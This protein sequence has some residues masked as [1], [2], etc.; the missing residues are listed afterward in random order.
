MEVRISL[1]VEF[2]F[3]VQILVAYRP[4]GMRTFPDTNISGL[5]LESA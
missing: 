2:D 5:Q 3:R 1:E 4:T